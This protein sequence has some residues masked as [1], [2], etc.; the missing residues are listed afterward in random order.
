[1]GVANVFAVV[2]GEAGRLKKR[3]KKKEKRK[4][5][6]NREEG[7]NAVAV[8]PAAVCRGKGGARLKIKD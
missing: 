3:K 6:K 5:R 8:I 4:K 2:S 1:M 7:K